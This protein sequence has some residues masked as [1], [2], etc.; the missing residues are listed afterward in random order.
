MNDEEK[1]QFTT[2]QNDIEQIKMIVKNQDLKVDKMYYALMGNEIAKDGGLVGRIQTL[3]KENEELREELEAF[4]TDKA[5]SD[6]YIK[7]IWALVSGLVSMVFGY[8]MTLIFKK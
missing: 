3:E 1:R 4:K 5:K 7:W 2:M 8:V 6:L